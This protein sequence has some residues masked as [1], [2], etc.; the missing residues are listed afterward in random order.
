MFTT[1]ALI[2]AVCVAPP[3]DAQVI[4]PFDV[5]DRI[6]ATL[7]VDTTRKMPVDHMLLGL[8]CNWPEGLYGKVGYNHPDAQKLINRLKPSSLRFPHGV[9]A[10]FYDWESDGRRMTDDYKTPYDSAVKG[11]PDLKYGFDGFYKLHQELDFD[12]LLTFNVN[13]DSPEKAA[14]RLRDRRDKGFD[15]K[16][17]ELGN[18]IFWKTQRS[19]AVIDVEK[20][21]EVSKAHA[22]ALREVD[23]GLKISV[24]AHWRNSRTDAW[25][26]ALKSQQDYF[27]AITVHKHI[28]AKPNAEGAR[29]VLHARVDM[30]KM[31]ED[32][33]SVFPGKPIWLSEWSVSCGESPISVIAMADAWLGLFEHPEL[34][35]IADYFQINASHALIHYDKSTRTHT[36]TSYGA[37]YEIIRSV[38]ENSEI[39][40]SKLITAKLDD[41]IEAVAAEAVVKDGRMIVFAINKTTNSVPLKITVDGVSFS[42]PATHRA[43]SF[44]ELNKLK[45]FG[46]DESVLAKVDVSGESKDGSFLLPPLSLSRFDQADDQ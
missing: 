16:W 42:L 5:S 45:S 8:N 18:E 21:I 12:V 22:T 23:P 38:F 34:F 7:N 15:V 37:A 13:Y 4:Y 6:T 20:Y 25:N 26:M 44:T 9:W 10:N 31:A 24:P 19:N 32:L 11:H 17:V 14:R 41:E 39:Y 30:L 2:V 1:A 29:Q 43:L 3:A 33:Q 35:A 28:G 40:E 27:D 36:R 46:L